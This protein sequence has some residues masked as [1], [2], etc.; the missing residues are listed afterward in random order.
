MPSINDVRAYWEQ[1]PLLS[2]EVGCVSPIEH[3]SILDEKKR[4]DIER[5]SLDFWKF[6]QTKGKRVLDIGCGPGWLTVKYA[7][8]GAMVTAIDLTESAVS[9]TESV[10]RA[11]SLKA[12]VQVGNAESLPFPDDS[13]EIV[14][15][16]GV[17]HHT[18]DTLKGFSEAFRVTTPGGQGLITLYR[19]SLLH[20]RW[21]FPLVRVLMKL[22]RARHPGADLASL[23][24]SAEEFV[25]MYDG[26]DNPI[27]IAQTTRK[28]QRDLE[29]VGWKVTTIETHYFPLRMVANLK[30]AP[31]WL[32]KLLDRYCGT[33][34]YF[35]L[36]KSLPTES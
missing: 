29:T 30:A 24:T 5:F 15:S 21:V 7:A 25:R 33:M 28:W 4:G 2:H 18:P 16:S 20:R 23:A 34:V 26:E 32:H 12:H 22:T 14:V 10:L 17:L 27:G 31:D 11:K 36:Q 8:A 3:W 19:L 13:F 6:E 35:S 1:Y 9:I